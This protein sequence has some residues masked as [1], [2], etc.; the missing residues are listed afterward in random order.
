MEKL[1]GLEPKKVFKYFEEISQI[2]RGSGNEKAISDYM[3]KF[4]K[5]RNL[6]VVQDSVNNILIKKEGTVGYENSIPLIIQGHMDMVCEKNADVEHDFLTEP[7]K[8]RVDGDFISAEGTT[9]GADNGIAVAIA[10][11][12]LDSDDIAHPPL[13]VVLTTDEEVG[14]NGAASF[15]GGLLKGKYLLNLDTEE[16]GKL[17]VSCCGG[18]K[19]DIKLPVEREEAGDNFVPYILQIKGLKG[20]HS[21]AD[22]HLQRA[23]AN[24]LLGRLL[25]DIFE[26]YDVKLS[27]LN[28]GSMD[29]AIT[30]ES[31]AILLVENKDVDDITALVKK[32]ESD[33]IAEFK[34][35]ESTVILNFESLN[36]KVIH[37]LTDE[38]AKKAIYILMLIPYGVLAM[39]LDM[40][41]LVESSSN[42]GILRTEENYIRFISAVRSSVKT[43]KYEIYN[44]LV[45]LARATQSEIEYRGDYPSWTFNPDS[46]LLGIFQQTHIDMYGKEA[47]VEAI[48]A[49]LECGMFAEK[50]ED[51]DMISVGP[52]MHDVHTP[53]E[54]LSISS[55]ARTW[56]YIKEVLK[57]LK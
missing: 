15:D 20:G 56:E 13:E 42:I 34:G 6:Y 21:G 27:S 50:V 38:T 24:K 57:R 35:A 44:K 1:Y 49:G 19:V 45:S 28:G 3:V 30:R 47:K 37:V 4:A 18:M 31:E 46:K 26:K 7:L 23:N 17:L 2:P 22:I 43:R 33:F 29:N 48:H 40:K 51:L 55:T 53:D 12:I 9:L 32:C 10:L 16:E 41:D 39:S 5:E 14:M 25:F 54:R 11:A 52:E 36:E 8:L